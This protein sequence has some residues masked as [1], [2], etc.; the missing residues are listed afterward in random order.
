MKRRWSPVTRISIKSGVFHRHEPKAAKIVMGKSLVRP[1][2]ARK[3]LGARNATARS[4]NDNHV[5]T[6]GSHTDLF[7]HLSRSL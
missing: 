6:M 1:S 3:D 2:G 5:L 4:A 7:G